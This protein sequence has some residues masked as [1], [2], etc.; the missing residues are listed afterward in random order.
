MDTVYSNRFGITTTDSGEVFLSFDMEIP[1]FNERG[2]S[3]GSD[4]KKG[5]TIVMSG[6]ALENFNEM[7]EKVIKGD[8]E[9]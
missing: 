2:E 5:I 3:V 7:V 4:I 9:K 8:K 1:K 6:N